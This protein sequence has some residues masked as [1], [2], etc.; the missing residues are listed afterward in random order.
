MG[1]GAERRFQHPSFLLIMLRKD[2]W[3]RHEPRFGFLLFKEFKTLLSFSI[4]PDFNPV[5]LRRIVRVI[6]SAAKLGLKK[7]VLSGLRETTNACLEYAPIVF[8][9][10]GKFLR[11][12]IVVTTR[13]GRL[14]GELPIE[15]RYPPGGSVDIDMTEVLEKLQLPNG[16]YIA[17]MVMTRGRMDGFRSSPGSY[18]MTY[19]NDRVY[20]TYRTGGFARALNDPNR[21]RHTGF[22]GIN[23]KVVVNDQFLSSLMLI[24]H[25]SDPLYNETAIPRSVLLRED[26][27]TREAEFGPIPP[28]GGIVKSMEDLFGTDVRDFL[29]SSGGRGTTITT[30]PGVTLASIHVMRARDGSSLSIEHSRPT[31]TYLLNGVAP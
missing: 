16:D 7:N 31:H 15:G 17:I 20:T 8:S 25:S 2:L 19:Y 30:C 6:G 14:V 23:P 22:R 26:G 1:D 28:F 11:F 5:E 27:E 29:A 21:K 12:R 18:S 4:R 24:N 10:D 3:L 13:D 9:S